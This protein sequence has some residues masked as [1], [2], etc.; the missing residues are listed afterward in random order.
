MTVNQIQARLRAAA[1][2]GALVD[3]AR[4]A[5]VS[6]AGASRWVRGERE[7]TLAFAVKLAGALGYE[8]VLRKRGTK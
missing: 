6:L 7:S 8:L 1:K 4:R 3:I 2:R 5:G